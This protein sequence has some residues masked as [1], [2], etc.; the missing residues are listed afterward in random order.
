VRDDTGAVLGD[1]Y[2][3]SDLPDR[4]RLQ[5]LLEA[6]VE[7]RTRELREASEQ[8]L[9]SERLAALGQFS[10]TMAHELRNPLNV[11]K[12]SVHY[13]TSHLRQPDEK[14]QRHLAHMN[15]YVDRACAII[16]DLL[17]FSRLP[18]P[19]LQPAP[20]N[21][22]VREVVL[23]L[24]IPERVAV[25]WALA[26]DLP[27]VPV[28]ARQIEQAVG[29]LGMNA[30]QAMPEGGRLIVSTRRVGECV[31]IG[32]RDT[33]PGVPE[34]LEEKVMEP[35]FSTKVT[36]TGLGLPLVREIA[37]AH[38]GRFTLQNL[39][40]E[41]ACFSLML[42]I[43]PAPVSSTPRTPPS[44]PAFSPDPEDHNEPAPRASV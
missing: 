1:L 20:L 22:L 26:S 41:G 3:Y 2:V 37:A 39:P 31:E 23:A 7:E 14:L 17:A 19:Q 9:R 8:L 33:G 16:N 34:G 44:D 4:E 10:A 24:T 38:G 15:E 30:L 13:V 12:L 5:D 29:N 21:E 35:F 28:D 42:P 32:V 27:P 11:V 40:G 18:P 6:R 43:Q 25:E 36:G